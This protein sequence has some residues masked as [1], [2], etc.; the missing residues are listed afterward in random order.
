VLNV[1]RVSE[2]QRVVA[3][4]SIP[5]IRGLSASSQAL[6]TTAIGPNALI[7]A[8]RLRRGMTQRDLAQILGISQSAICQWE[9]GFAWPDGAHLSALLYALAAQPEEGFALSSFPDNMAMTGLESLDS[10]ALG[11]KQLL[12]PTAYGGGNDLLDLQALAL[13]ESANRLAYNEVCPG[14]AHELKGEIEAAYAQTLVLHGRLRE[15]LRACDR[16][17]ATPR[18][19]HQPRYVYRATIIRAD[20]V[21]KGAPGSV[22]SAITDLIRLADTITSPRCFWQYSY[23]S[24][25]ASTIADGYAKLDRAALALQYFGEAQR[26]SMEHEPHSLELERWNA[27]LLNVLGLHH[28]AL[29]VAERALEQEPINEMDRLRRPAVRLEWVRAAVRVG[30]MSPASVQLEVSRKEISEMNV[31]YLVPF[32]FELQSSLDQ[33]S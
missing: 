10:V 23:R 20:A 19:G 26:F 24:W 8:M 28:Q 9:Q 18:P 32:V 29:E 5:R 31:S 7:R 14:A 3:L 13:N 27:K 21:I 16:S 33:L 15:A 6:H 11:L 4:E 2:S 22:K 25:I 30:L 1:L 17:L 12:R